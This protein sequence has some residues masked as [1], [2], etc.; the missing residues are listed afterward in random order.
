M[1]QPFQTFVSNR[2]REIAQTLKQTNS[3]YAENEDT[4]T[5][6]MDD[7]SLA[8]NNPGEWK[9]NARSWEDLGELLQRKDKRLALLQRESYL[10]GCLD[11]VKILKMLRVIC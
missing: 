6:I 8:L 11:C 7:F 4:I 10:Q 9:T 5:M 1:N 2:L 3:E